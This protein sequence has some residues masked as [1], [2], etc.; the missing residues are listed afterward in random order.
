MVGAFICIISLGRNVYG[1]APIKGKIQIPPEIAE[2]I[3]ISE[4]KPFLKSPDGRIK[5]ADVRRLVQIGDKNAVGILV[6]VF[7]NE[8]AG[9]F[10]YVKEEII[11]ALAVLFNKSSL[12]I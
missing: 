2:D 1:E 7:E 6:K 5:I 9:T 8:P 10:P 12:T 11:K 3:T 4:I